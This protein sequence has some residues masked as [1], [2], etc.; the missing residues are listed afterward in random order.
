MASEQAVSIHQVVGFKSLGLA[1]KPINK[2]FLEFLI[3][4]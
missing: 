4:A 1:K 3:A 2:G